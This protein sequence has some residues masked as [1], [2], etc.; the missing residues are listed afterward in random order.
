VGPDDVYLA[1][2]GLRT[3]GVR[4]RQHE[5]NAWVIANWL[6][7][8]PV[9]DRVIYPALPNDPGHEIGKR[10]FTGASGLFGIV[11]KTGTE[12]QIAALLDGM[13][14]FGMGYSWGGYESLLIHV[15]LR[16]ARTATKWEPGGTF[17]RIHVGLEDPAD[18]IEDL[19]A[20]FERYQASEVNAT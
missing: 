18:L 16:S 3:L 1:Q 6:Q 17:F 4:L 5:K 20:G 15:P 14:L 13:K 10:D 2:R 12:R 8:Q 7:N 9:V 11:L 19:T